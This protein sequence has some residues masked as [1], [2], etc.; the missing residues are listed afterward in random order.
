MTIIFEKVHTSLLIKS[1]KNTKIIKIIKFIKAALQR[2]SPG[3]FLNQSEHANTNTG[4]TEAFHIYIEP[5]F[6][7]HI[8]LN[9]PFSIFLYQ[10]EQMIKI[11]NIPFYEDSR[12]WQTKARLSTS[13]LSSCSPWSLKWTRMA[14]ISHVVCS[15]G[16]GK[17]LAHLDR[18]KR[19]HYAFE[20]NHYE[21]SN[22]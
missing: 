16:W 22:W 14:I 3:S 8:M 13:A 19:H 18:W 11:L 4:W 20:G 9:Y 6:L 12:I 21:Y 2:T 1:F 15:Q 5:L 7:H 17:W 10:S